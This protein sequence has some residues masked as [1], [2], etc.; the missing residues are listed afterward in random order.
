[1]KRAALTEQR[2]SFDLKAD[3]GLVSIASRILT[4]PTCYEIYFRGTNRNGFINE[5]KMSFIYDRKISRLVF[6][7]MIMR[8][9]VIGSPFVF[10]DFTSG[11]RDEKFSVFDTF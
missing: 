3:G 11:Q 4:A 10:S 5:G 9:R 6:V 2:A 7:R 1:M 8:R